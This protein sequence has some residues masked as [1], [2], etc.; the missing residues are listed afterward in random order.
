MR[1]L[2]Y[3][4]IAGL[5]VAM[6]GAAAAQAQQADP[7]SFHRPRQLPAPNYPAPGYPGPSCPTPQMPAPTPSKE[8]AQP[9]KEGEQP[10]KKDETQQPQTPDFSQQAPE[11][12]T[13]GPGG[14]SAAFVSM[15]GDSFGG[16]SGTSTIIVNVPHSFTGLG[17]LLINPPAQ[18][19]ANTPV[20]FAIYNPQV[21]QQL[22][23]GTLHPTPSGIIPGKPFLQ[24]ATEPASSTVFPLLTNQPH[25][26]GTLT[27]LPTGN[28]RA[29]QPLVIQQNTGIASRSGQTTG[30]AGPVEVFNVSYVELQQQ[31][32]NLPHP[33]QA[34]VSGHVRLPEGNNPLPRDRLIFDYDFF[35]N[36]TLTSTGYDVNRFNL[37]FE[38]TFLDGTGSLEV[39]FP[40][41]ATLNSD[42]IVGS[43]PSG[44]QV[45]FQNTRTQFGNAH[46]TLKGLL[47]SDKN[48]AFSTGLGIDLPTAPGQHVFSANTLAQ[49]TLMNLPLAQR[50][51][52]VE[53]VNWHNRTIY[54][55]PY[56]AGIF[57]PTDRI[58]MQSWAT[59]DFATRGNPIEVV[60]QSFT[61]LQS[62]GSLKDQTTLQ[63]DTQVGYWIVR[64]KDQNRWL[65]GLAP[66]VE[67][68]FTTALN[69]AGTITSNNFILSNAMG[70]DQLTLTSGILTQIS[71]NS[72]LTVGAVTPLQDRIFNYQIGVRFNVFYGYTARQMTRATAVSTF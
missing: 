2:F 69:D 39:R 64:S 7:V 9:G 28:G 71:N 65:R 63:L 36:T 55:E 26:N 62:A 45:A 52:P 58:F 22:E 61:A 25:T 10:E 14:G 60:N 70:S 29:Q 59:I 32:L 31:T 35:S 15:L 38:K 53:L 49:A 24:T 8:G 41:S 5:G 27:S 23:N 12:G 67:V 30:A 13:A 19:S 66:F 16:G 56:I 72:T 54:L 37:G 57:T 20:S 21:T 4:W 34:I 6:T 18:L 46:L 42:L 3:R 48:M 1:R 11:A 68:H 17:G 40:F 47:Y 33:S 44:N 50:N 43:D 51:N